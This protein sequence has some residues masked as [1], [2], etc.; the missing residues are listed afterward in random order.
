MQTRHGGFGRSFP[1][2]IFS[3]GIRCYECSCAVFERIRT[4]VACVA[5]FNVQVHQ[6][7]NNAVPSRVRAVLATAL[8]EDKLVLSAKLCPDDTSEHMLKQLTAV[9]NAQVVADRSP[10]QLVY[11]DNVMKFAPWCEFAR[12]ARTH[13]SHTVCGT[14][15]PLPFMNGKINSTDNTI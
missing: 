2:F 8:N 11:V 3:Y 12:I 9:V 6:K 7:R 5:L 1:R 13:I 15:F 4:A 14:P 10:T